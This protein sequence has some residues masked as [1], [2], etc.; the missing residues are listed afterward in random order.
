MIKS[1]CKYLIR[2]GRAVRSCQALTAAGLPYVYAVD[3]V[4]NAFGVSMLDVLEA[5]GES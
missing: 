2:L 1:R 4:S 3:A 5:V